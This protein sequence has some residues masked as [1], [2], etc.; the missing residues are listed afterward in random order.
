MAKKRSQRQHRP[1][2]KAELLARLP[3]VFRPQL[4]Q[5][6]RTDLALL[7][8]SNLDAIAMGGATEDNL[9]QWVGSVLTWTKCAELLERGVDDMHAQLDLATRLVNRYRQTGR[10]LFTGVDYQLAKAGVEIMDALAETADRPTAMVAADW[11]EATLE[12]MHQA[13]V[14]YRAQQALGGVAA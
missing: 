5:G 6:Q 1:L 14:G 4:D 11:G 3:R 12:R 8:I 13:V 7:H 9:W 2:S 10:I